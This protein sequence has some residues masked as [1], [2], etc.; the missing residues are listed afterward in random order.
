MK[1]LF[2]LVSGL[3]LLLTSLTACSAAD[4]QVKVLLETSKGPIELELYPSKAPKTVENFLR[5][6][7]E[8]FYE[9]T[10]FHRVINSFMIQGGGFDAELNQ[11]PTHDQ[12]HNEAD[13]RLKNERGTVAMARTEAPNSATS[14]FFINHVDNNFLDHRDKSPKGWGYCVFGKVT[15]GMETVDAIADVFTT[16]KNGMQNVPEEPVL[17][18]KASRLAVPQT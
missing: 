16:T 4:N 1:T 15:K 9:N 14:Q 2:H 13:N 7:D 18:I 17:I 5:Y 11:K 12:I 6:V 10:V 3:L 8:G